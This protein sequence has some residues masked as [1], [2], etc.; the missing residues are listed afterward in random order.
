MQKLEIK[1]KNRK[2][3]SVNFR[4]TKERMEKFMKKLKE[5]GIDN[6]VDFFESAMDAFI[7]GKLF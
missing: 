7:E 5:K 2:D 6:Q 1:T 3:K 4:T